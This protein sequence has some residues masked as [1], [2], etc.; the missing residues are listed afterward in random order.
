MMT[1]LRRLALDWLV[2]FGILAGSLHAVYLATHTHVRVDHGG[3]TVSVAGWSVASYNGENTGVVVGV[4]TG[5][6]AGIEYW[7]T[8]SPVDTIDAYAYMRGC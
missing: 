4:P 2:T 7:H 6:C 1:G 8:D 5:A 3:V